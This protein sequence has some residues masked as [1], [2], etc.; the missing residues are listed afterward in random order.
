VRISN[1][2]VVAVLLLW[3]SAPPMA[4]QLKPREIPYAFNKPIAERLLPDDVIVQVHRSYDFPI[5][6]KSLRPIDILQQPVPSS[7]YGR[8]Q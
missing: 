3:V 4:T 5:Y 7:Y 8:A 6:E 1:S 2:I